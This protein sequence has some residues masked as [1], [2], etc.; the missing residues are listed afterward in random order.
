MIIKKKKIKFFVQNARGMQKTP[1]SFFFSGNPT[2]IIFGINRKI[3]QIPKNLVRTICRYFHRE[4]AWLEKVCQWRSERAVSKR[5]ESKVNY[6]KVVRL[7]PFKKLCKEHKD[8]FVSACSKMLVG[9]ILKLFVKRGSKERSLLL[10]YGMHTAP[11]F[12]FLKNEHRNSQC[13]SDPVE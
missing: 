12:F 5:G 10:L 4:P 1:A 3:I 9:A 7:T 2:L 13:N 6:L 8:V 11:V